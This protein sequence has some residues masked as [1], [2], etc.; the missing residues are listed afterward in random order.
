MHF[1][2]DT[3]LSGSSA[4]LYSVITYVSPVTK[5]NLVKLLIGADSEELG[6]YAYNPERY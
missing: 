5:G 4:I 3:P 6:I 1:E 2:P